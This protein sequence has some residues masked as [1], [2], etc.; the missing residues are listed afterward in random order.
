VDPREV[1]TRRC[2]EIG[3]DET[4]TSGTG[5]TVGRAGRAASARELPRIS[6][7]LA[8]TLPGTGLPAKMEAANAEKD[9]EILSLI[10]EGGMGRVFLAHQHSLDRDVA[11]KTVH[12]DATA[13][14]RAAL[15]AEG[16][17]TGHLEHPSIVPVHALGVDATSSPVLVMKR[18]EG[19]EWGKL[20][21]DPDHAAWQG[22][23]GSPA[24]RLVGHLEILMQVCN[25][26]HFAHTRGLLHRDIKPANVLVGYFGEV[27]LGDWGLALRLEAAEGPHALCGTPSYLAPEM[28]VGGMLDA[29]TDVYLL[30][31]TL[32]HILT[33]QPRHAGNTIQ[34]A[35]I[36][37]ARSA[38]FA[39]P[40][41]IPEEL[42]TLANRATARDPAARPES[43]ARFREHI[44]DFLRHRS[45][46]ALA[47][48]A[49]ERL[50]QLRALPQAGLA[51]V[52]TQDR[53]D[54]LGAE[55]RFA[56]ER[57]QEEWPENPVAKQAGE[58]LDALLAARRAR[59]AELE[60]LA[61][62]HD[63]IVS[64]R[65]RT[66]VFVIMA[67]IGAALSVQ[68]LVADA[69]S[70]TPRRFFH[71]SLVPLGGT[72]LIGVWLRHHIFRTALNRRAGFGLLTLVLG[73]SVS[74][75]LGLAAGFTVPQMV[76]C[77]LLFIVGVS[78]CLAA[79]VFRW[80]AWCTLIA[81]ASAV[82]AALSPER[83]VLAFSLGSG[84]G[85]VLAA[86]LAWR[87][88]R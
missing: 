76:L 71:V 35:L 1:V 63:P 28:A 49:V 64:S 50:A 88:E 2:V 42:A 86:F 73:I 75:A 65:Q 59:A 57:A 5:A 27:Y 78:A 48:S 85:L 22:R 38:P 45:S 53:I 62:D 47:R 21:D 7:D 46:A 30:G 61:H 58:E 11:I 84:V 10:G 29:R 4:A 40:P 67:L 25:A 66:L 60:R 20:L 55:V 87:S 37:A 15:L 32:H 80:I 43:A 12:A 74:R 23:G 9:L 3:L 82:I 70:L 77:D 41:A 83:A 54:R 33:G 19:V 39:Y 18:V 31:A 34:D 6:V 8:R 81:L 36:G 56:I 79:S 16:A 17:V 44:A 26:A 69:S 72:L 68:A 24:D 14:E 52:D 13:R 51:S